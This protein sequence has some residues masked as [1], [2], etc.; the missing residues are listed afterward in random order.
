MTKGNGNRVCPWCTEVNTG[1]WVQIKCPK[2]GVETWVCGLC[3][4]E[5]E[6]EDKE[7]VAE[8]IAAHYNYLEE[9]C[10]NA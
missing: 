7:D 8:F 4:A 1:G 6:N 2:T 9:E 10:E 3:A 5:L